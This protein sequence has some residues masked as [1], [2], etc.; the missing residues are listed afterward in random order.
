MKKYMN[1]IKGNQKDLFML[2][3]KIIKEKKN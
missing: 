2:K 3:D 1:K